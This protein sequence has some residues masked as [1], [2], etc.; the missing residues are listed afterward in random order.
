MPDPSRIDQPF[1]QEKQTELEEEWEGFGISPVEQDSSSSIIK[2]A[3]SSSRKTVSKTPQIARKA[4][5]LRAKKESQKSKV[6]NFQSKNEFEALVDA[7]T[8]EVDG[9]LDSTTLQS[10]NH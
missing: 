10:T 2:S 6:E 7:T 3:A 8:G 5:K 1:S 9:R 4:Q